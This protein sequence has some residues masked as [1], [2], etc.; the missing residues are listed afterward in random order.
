MWI[1]S[2]PLPVKSAS[3]RAEEL[4][5]LQIAAVEELHKPPLLRRAGGSQSDE[6]QEGG[7]DG[8][9]GLHRLAPSARHGDSRSQGARSQ[10]RFA[11]LGPSSFVYRTPARERTSY[12]MNV[13]V[14][15]R[16][17]PGR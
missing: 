9:S 15:W 13:V 14:T 7:S 10:A 17:P 11:P 2:P 16:P 6:Q 12:Q 1:S 5:A 4:K 3:R 8:R